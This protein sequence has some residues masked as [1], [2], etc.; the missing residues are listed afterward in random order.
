MTWPTIHMLRDLRSGWTDAAQAALVAHSQW[1]QLPPFDELHHPAI[2]NCRDYDP[3]TLSKRFQPHKAASKNAGYLVIEAR[4]KSKG[5]GWRTAIVNAEGQFWAVFAAPHDAFH[6]QVADRFKGDNR[7]QTEP[8]QDDIDVRALVL[9]RISTERALRA[10]KESL[11]R[12]TL[13]VFREAWRAEELSAEIELP[14]PPQTLLPP[15]ISQV[16]ARIG[17]QLVRGEEVLAALTRSN[18]A[19]EVLTEILITLTPPVRAGDPIADQIIRTVLPVLDVNE[20]HWV[21]DSIYTKDGSILFPSAL[22]TNQVAQALFAAE[23][24]GDNH[25]DV[26]ELQPT[27]L[28]HY[29]SASSIVDSIVN[30]QPM[31]SACGIWLVSRQDPDGMDV[32]DECIEQLPI[33]SAVRELLRGF[34]SEP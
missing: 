30:G 23:V 12:A 1:N 32:C 16:D 8:T 17:I 4:D 6:K 34:P 19:D 13:S 18:M 31:R 26:G 21:K 27:A 24:E 10:W 5:P 7:K 2:R 33:V 9:S 3:S 14:E 29:V 20:D 28:A 11:V 22:R 15:G 25:L